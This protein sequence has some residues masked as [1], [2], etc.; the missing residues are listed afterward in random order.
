MGAVLDIVFPVFALMGI[1][2]AL[3][4]S[5]LLGGDVGIKALTNFV[6]YAAI[7]ALLFRLFSRGLPEDGIEWSIIFGYFGAALLHFALTVALGRYVFRNPP[8]E[9]GLMGMASSFSNTVLMG[10]PLVY[11]T[12]GEPG[13]IPMMMIV[14]FHPMILIPLSTIRWRPCAARRGRESGP[15]CSPPSGVW[16]CIRSSS[17]CAAGWPSVRRGWNWCRWSTG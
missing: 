14:T 6:F 4:R 1:G 11:T 13:L 16:R 8:V 3:G 7:P 10:L 12:F 17:A 2:Y 5:P 9:Y 15:S